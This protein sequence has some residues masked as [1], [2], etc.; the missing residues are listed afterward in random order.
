LGFVIILGY[1]RVNPAPRGN[2]SVTTDAFRWQ[3]LHLLH[4]GYRNI[5]LEEVAASLP[6]LPR[7]AFAITLDDGYRDNYFHAMPILAELRL[8]ATLFVT[9]NYIGTD[10]PYVWDD[11]RRV[12]WGGDVR[13]EDLSVSWSQL[14]EM[15]ES[16]LFTVGSHTLSHPE[17]P[18]VDTDTARHEITASKQVL[19]ER[20]L[21]PVTAFCYPRGELNHE[22]IAMVKDAGY[23]LGVVTPER[24]VPRSNHTLRRVGIDAKHTDR[25]FAFKVSPVFQLLLASGIWPRYRAVQAKR[26]DLRAV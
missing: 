5:S 2:L 17:L 21:R 6:R 22:V 26:R 18:S 13:E 19:E 9:V 14:H 25:Q 16:G 24:P 11:Q 10:R 8:T 3:L 7:R 4:K 23:A 20:L 15:Q 1:H 12:Q